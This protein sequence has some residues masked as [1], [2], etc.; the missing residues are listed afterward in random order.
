MN[1]NT[2]VMNFNAKPLVGLALRQLSHLGTLTQ[3]RQRGG[4]VR[5]RHHLRPWIMRRRRR[6]RRGLWR[7]ST[8]SERRHERSDRTTPTSA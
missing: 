7:R 1:F 5:E 2:K 6:W 3:P 4:A 8:R